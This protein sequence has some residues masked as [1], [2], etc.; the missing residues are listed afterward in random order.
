MDRATF[1]AQYPEFDATP[2]ALVDAKLADAT[3]RTD[4]DA[5]GEDA[6]AAIGLYAAHL[7]EISPQGRPARKEGADKGEDLYY[8]EWKRLA[9]QRLGVPRAIGRW[10]R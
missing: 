3:R 2:D 9:Q 4:A 1:R 7:L 8:L 5:F 10:Q 6:D